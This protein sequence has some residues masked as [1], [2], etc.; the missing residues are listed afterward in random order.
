MVSDSRLV[1][2]YTIKHSLRLL[3]YKVM[4]LIGKHRSRSSPSCV[5]LQTINAIRDRTRARV[6]LHDELPGLQERLL[7]LM[8]TEEGGSLHCAAFEAAMECLSHLVFEDQ[9]VQQ[10]SP[11]K[12]RLLIAK[13]QIGAV[14]GKG[15]STIK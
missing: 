3:L 15:G 11:A 8:S 13:D 6:M 4:E 12:L 9:S 14:M 7:S 2:N 5:L 1:K 10:G